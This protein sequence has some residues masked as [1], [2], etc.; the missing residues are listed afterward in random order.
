[1]GAGNFADDCESQTGPVC[2][3][4]DEGLEQPL[5]D[6]FWNPRPSVMYAKAN[7]A[8]ATVGFYF[9]RSAGRRVLDRVEN[10]IVKRAMHLFG[11]ECWRWRRRAAF[12]GLK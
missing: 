12:R 11:V 7:P 10:E 2:P 9:H 8:I 4:G 6:A 1:M 3:P 5:T